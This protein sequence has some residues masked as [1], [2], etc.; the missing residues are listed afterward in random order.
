MGVASAG[1][2]RG[3]AVGV[4]N[5]PMSH[6]TK[7]RRAVREPGTSPINRGRGWAPRAGAAVISRRSSA[8]RSGGRRGGRDEGRAGTTIMSSSGVGPR[9]ACPAPFNARSPGTRVR[10]PGR[11]SRV[12]GPSG[13]GFRPGVLELRPTSGLYRG[14]EPTARSRAAARLTAAAACRSDGGLRY[15]PTNGSP[16]PDGRE[17]WCRAARP[18]WRAARSAGRSS[19]CRWDGSAAV[20]RHRPCARP[21]GRRGT[22]FFLRLPDP[23]PRTG[24]ALAWISWDHPRMP[25]GWHR[26]CG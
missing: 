7:R 17:I 19:R 6:E 13:G 26:S 10:R 1:L 18:T 2:G 5:R 25:W 11:T 24:P 8:T 9:A 16:P 21:G 23:V 20:G 14:R 4:W 22:F 12:S 15:G 3:D